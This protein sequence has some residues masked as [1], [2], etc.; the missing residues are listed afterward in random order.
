VNDV[1]FCRTL[2]GTIAV[3][4]RAV[5]DGSFIDLAGFDREVSRLSDSVIRRPAAE[6]SD[7]AA[8][9]GALRRDLDELSAVLTA[10]AGAESDA[11]RRRAAQAYAPA[12]KPA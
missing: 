5:A 4:R 2:R 10:Q 7:I 12:G 9:L 8:E 1:E 6:R 11:A 3:A